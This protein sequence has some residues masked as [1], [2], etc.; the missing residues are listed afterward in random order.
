MQ[1]AAA[2]AASAEFAVG[3]DKN[4]SVIEISAQLS[5]IK[6][7]VKGRLLLFFWFMHR[8]C[9]YKLCGPGM[10]DVCSPFTV[11]ILCDVRAS[12]GPTL[13]GIDIFFFFPP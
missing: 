3:N 10:D 9:L 1:T 2:A 4:E 11:N 6:I 5:D 12:L 7:V 13:D 8:D